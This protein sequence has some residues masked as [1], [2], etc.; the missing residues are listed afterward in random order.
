[1]KGKMEWNRRIFVALITLIW[2]T[3]Q[4]K[5][6]Q[7]RK[8]IFREF[9]GDSLSSEVRNLRLNVNKKKPVKFN[10]SNDLSFK[11]L[12]NPLFSNTFE[13]LIHSKNYIKTLTQKV[14]FFFFRTLIQKL[15]ISMSV[16]ASYLHSSTCIWFSSALFKHKMG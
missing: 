9:F 14:I 6:V 5:T 7:W 3:V 10:I 4:R 16:V 2:R 11:M 8:Q 13:S 1:M 15:W 12:L